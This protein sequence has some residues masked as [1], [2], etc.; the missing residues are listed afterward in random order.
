MIPTT[1]AGG[2][3]AALA[4]VPTSSLARPVTA[5]SARYRG[6]A[7]T[8][9]RV[10]RSETDVLAYLAYRMPATFA[11]VE[12]ALRATAER[13]PDW[14]PRTVLDLDAGPGTAI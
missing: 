2:I 3:E 8:G 9:G 11:A 4:G 1:L 6:E 12:A 7:P 10:L 14:Q 5:V 13:R